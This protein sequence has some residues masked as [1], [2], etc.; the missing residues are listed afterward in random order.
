M[1]PQPHVDATHLAQSYVQYFLDRPLT[2][3]I[4]TASYNG[5]AGGLVDV[6]DKS[7]FI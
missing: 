5:E 6:E 4:Q 2:S 1:L 7:P 3:I